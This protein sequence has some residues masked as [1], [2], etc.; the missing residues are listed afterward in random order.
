MELETKDVQSTPAAQNSEKFLDGQMFADMVRGG[1][2]QL[3]SNAKEVNDLN[4]FPVPDGDTGD[5]MSMTIEGGVAALE[6]VHSDDLAAVTQTLSKGMLLGARGNSGVILSQF[7]AGMTKGFSK[8]KR[9]DSRV[10]GEAMQEGV[11]QAYASVITP[12]EGTILT[13]AR[14]AVEYAVSRITDATTIKTLFADLLKEMYNSLQRTPELLTALKEANVIDSGGA[15][16]FYIMQGFNKILRGEKVD[17]AEA[18]PQVKNPSLNLS[19]FTADSEMTYGYCTE[20]LL[21]LLNARVDTEAFDVKVISDYLQT[22]GDSIVA[23]KTDSIVKI[24]V[25]TKTPEKVLEFC[26]RYG[27]FLTVKIENMSVQHSQAL[28]EEESEAQPP[29]PVKDYGTVAVAMGDGIRELFT[30]L[31]VDAVVHGG[32]TQNP[33]AQDFLAAFEEVNA[34]HIFVF[35]NNGN[36]VMAAKQAGQLYENGE[37]HVIE[38]KD[39]GQ[40]YAAISALNFE[41]DDP[42]Q[43]TQMLTSAMHMVTTGNISTAI[44]DAELNGVHIENGDFIGFV[45][46]SMK[47]SC[48]TLQQAAREL[49][50]KMSEDEVYLITAF[51]GKDASPEDVQ[52]LE[53]WI[54]ETYPDAEFYTV[55]GGQDVYPLIFVVE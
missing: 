34:R 19:A 30:K 28:T 32:Q 52:A 54:G 3:R 1:A 21:Q 33:S 48:K 14:E 17:E 42:E 18:L 46:K 25:H 38:S 49:L 15:G 41:S 47:V 29:R 39:L 6:G 26:R 5:N 55:D 31:G 8:Y 45:G 35:P 9:A 24:H 23:F 13:V 4:V 40:G 53:A 36:I 37:V 44:R 12:T 10:V 7:F 11:K 50:T 2:A 27:E 43:I 22:L 16:L 20:L 51:V